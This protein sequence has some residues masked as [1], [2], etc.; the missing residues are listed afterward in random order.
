MTK[1]VIPHLRALGVNQHWAEHAYM[2][3]EATK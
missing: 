1:D 3:V 2:I